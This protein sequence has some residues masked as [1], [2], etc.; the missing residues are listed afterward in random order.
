MNITMV[1]N[2]AT[3][4]LFHLEKRLDALVDSHDSVLIK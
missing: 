2:I 4:L 3:Q 1:Y